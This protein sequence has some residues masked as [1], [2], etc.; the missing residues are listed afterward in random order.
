MKPGTG[1][2]CFWNDDRGEILIEF[3][4]SICVLLAVIFGTMG[5]AWALYALHFLPF[6]ASE[7][8]RYASVRG[9]TWAGTNCVTVSTFS[10]DATSADINKYVQSIA[11]P[12]LV[13]SAIHTTTTWPATIPSGA[14]CVSTNGPNSPSCLVKVVITYDFNFSMPFLPS[15]ALPLT[16]TSEKI[17]LE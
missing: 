7:A 17:V 4:L 10:C 6:A 13:A 2:V 14:G 11:A 9:S 12:G 16:A 5:F 8:T 15:A 1:L 3:V